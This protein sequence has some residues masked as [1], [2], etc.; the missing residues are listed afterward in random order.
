MP[1]D[2]TP[3]EFNPVASHRNALDRAALRW[4]SQ[5]F[6]GRAEDL[7]AGIPLLRYFGGVDDM[8]YRG[9]K[10]SMERQ[11]Q[12]VEL[13]EAFTGTPEGGAKVV[14]LAP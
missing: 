4:Q 13:I 5:I 1:P 2:F 3:I 6:R 12:I 11:R 14:P 7:A 10:Y 8:A 9:P